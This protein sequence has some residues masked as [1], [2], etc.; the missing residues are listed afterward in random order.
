MSLF[1]KR[2]QQGFRI[3]GLWLGALSMITAA[4]ALVL[5][6]G[7]T[8]DDAKIS[9]AEKA[10]FEDAVSKFMSTTNAPGISAAKGPPFPMCHDPL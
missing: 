7:L 5:A 10:Q 3:A 8:A 1:L 6:S 2:E 4:F 9:A